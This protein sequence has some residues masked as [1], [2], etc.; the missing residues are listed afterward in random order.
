LN[1]P[2]AGIGHNGGP[3][4]EWVRPKL[5]A[6]QQAALFDAFDPEGNPARYA[7]IEASTKAG[8]TVGCMAWLAEQAMLGGGEG[9]EY[10]WVA[11]VYAQAAIAFRRMRRALPLWVQAAVNKTDMT[12]E[13]PNGAVLRFRSGENPDNL[14]G[15]DVYGAVVDEAS[16]MR[17]EAWFALRSTLTETRGPV[18]LIGN[19]KGRRNWFFLGCR[20]AEQGLSN[21]AYA[22]LTAYDAVAGGVLRKEEIDDAKALLPDHVFRELYLA[23][24][25]DDGGNPFGL[26]HIAACVEPG[27]SENR[28]V[29]VGVDL[30]KSVDYT[31]VVGLDRYGR[32]TGME[33][34]RD[35]WKVT[36]AKVIAL[37]GKLPA[38][39]DSTGVGNPV[40]EDITAQCL[41]AEG[42]VFTSRSKQMLMEGLAV[43]IQNRETGYPDGTIRAELDLF[44][45]VTTRTA[46]QYS[47]P[48]GY[49][50]DC[51]CALALAKEMH[52]RLYP[53][54]SK[55][56]GPAGST[57][58]S[59][60]VGG[61]ENG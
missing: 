14:Y 40:V 53:V 3:T 35:S 37:I 13:L 45:Y 9:R 57:R 20:K 39:I 5:Y 15:E 49:H 11:P 50:D 56:V 58:V 36:R 29:C 8:K 10:W 44:E 21:H 12:I 47:A 6:A 18:R 2:V 27:Y 38:L 61:D 19:V 33:R 32:V 42:F 25:S 54:G 16:R 24:P 52:R 26:S 28:T 48:V 59:P 23:E 1:A 51:V 43:A 30:A 41:R 46:V 17:E 60:W 31:V 55:A 34:W 7:W 22:K 4:L